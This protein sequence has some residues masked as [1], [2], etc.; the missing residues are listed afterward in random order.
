M[1]LLRLIR[2]GWAWGNE[3]VGWEI[4]K[5]SFLSC[6]RIRKLDV[7][8]WEVSTH[9]QWALSVAHGGQEAREYGF[10]SACG[11]TRLYSHGGCNH[12]F[13][14]WSPWPLPG[15][16]HLI[17]Y[18]LNGFKMMMMVVITT[19]I[20]TTISPANLYWVLLH[21][22]ILSKHL[23]CF[24]LLKFSL[25]PAHF[26]FFFLHKETVAYKGQ[27]TSSMSHSL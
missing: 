20:I 8:V 26:F 17:T 24:Y 12:H 9:G 19:I 14:S 11:Y 27:L 13:L 3:E 18:L 15:C 10:H 5:P 21:E 2:I 16:P 22:I 25:P 1:T 4:M 23:L 6:L 7:L